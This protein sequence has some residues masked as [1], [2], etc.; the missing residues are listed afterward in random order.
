MAAEN[1]IILTAYRVQLEE[2]Y[3][4]H[5][6]YLD[7]VSPQL[8]EVPE[9][10]DEFPVNLSLAFDRA[11]WNRLS[12]ALTVDLAIS[13]PLRIEVS[14]AGVFVL[15]PEVRRR[16]A[17][18]VFRKAA[19]EVAPVVLYP[20]IRETISNLTLR[21]RSGGIVVP[22]L[23]FTPITEQNIEIPAAPRLSR[24][25]ATP[26]NRTSTEASA[27]AGQ[28]AAKPRKKGTKPK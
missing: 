17:D 3:L 10:P 12:V 8:T 13:R 16:D 25:V 15:Q 2:V 26:R 9:L 19:A 18:S 21:G 1:P 24:S 14:Y 20:Y 4:L 6:R 5:A 28:G 27:S 7:T 23:G 11:T 22:I